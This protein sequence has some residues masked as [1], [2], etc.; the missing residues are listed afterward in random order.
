MTRVDFHVNV[1]D[2]IDYACRLIRKVRKAGQRAV[3]FCEDE[4]RL[5]EFD[6]ALW[7]FS[8]LEFIPH[9]PDSDPLA[10]RTPVLLTT[11]VEELPH[12]EVLVNLGASLPPF[13][14]RFDRLV[15]LVSDEPEDVVQARQRYRH[16]KDRGYPLETHDMNMSS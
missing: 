2:K 4:S 11:R 14:T 15:E 16:Y 9:L 8:P 3:V 7:S 1:G 6:A 5:R 13:F 12:H 10:S